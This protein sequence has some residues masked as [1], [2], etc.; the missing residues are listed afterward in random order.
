MIQNHGRLALSI[1]VLIL[2]ASAGR[3]QAGFRTSV[4]ANYEAECKVRQMRRRRTNKIYVHSDTVDAQLLRGDE[5]S[6]L[7][8]DNSGRVCV[9]ARRPTTTY[10]HAPLSVITGSYSARRIVDI[11]GPEERPEDENR[12]KRCCEVSYGYEP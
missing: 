11:Y 6:F 7:P 1:G 12:M 10:S 2:L 8:D 5:S 3:V 9:C 4:I